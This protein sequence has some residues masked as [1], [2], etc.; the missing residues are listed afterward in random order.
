M[1]LSEL[2]ILELCCRVSCL[3]WTRCCRVWQLP[4][5]RRYSIN[6][7]S[8]VGSPNPQLWDQHHQSLSGGTN[9]PSAVASNNPQ[10]SYIS[11]VVSRNPHHKL[12]HAVAVISTNPKQQ[13]RCT[14]HR[15]NGEVPEFHAEGHGRGNHRECAEIPGK[16]WKFQRRCRNLGRREENQGDTCR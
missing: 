2:P 5:S 15:R 12:A 13:Q 1:L 3:F 11:A 10:Q 9:N 4:E 16:I 7:P 14:I 6:K 8:A